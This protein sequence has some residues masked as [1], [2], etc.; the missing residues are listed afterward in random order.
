MSTFSHKSSKDGQTYTSTIV[1]TSPFATTLSGTAINAVVVPI[2]VTIKST[3]FDPTTPDPCD[4]VPAQTRFYY[5]PLANNVP[6]LTILGTN[7]GTTQFTNGFR[8]AEFW[9]AIGTAKGSAYQNAINFAFPYLGRV[10]RLRPLTPRRLDCECANQSGCTS[11]MGVLPPGWMK[12]HLEATVIPTLQSWGVIS[13]ASFV[14]FL[15]RNVVEA[16]SVDGNGN[17]VGFRLGYHAATG[18]PTQTY[19][20]VDWDTVNFFGSADA[21]VASHEI[22]EWMDDP[23]LTNATPPWGKVGQVQVSAS[24]PSGCISQWET[25]DPLTGK[26]MPVI[27]VPADPFQFSYHMQEL[28]Y[29]GFF[30]NSP[31]D[32]SGGATFSQVPRWHV[33]NQRI[34]YGTCQHLPDTGRSHPVSVR[35]RP[36]HESAFCSIAINHGVTT[37][38]RP[39]SPWAPCH[40][41]PIYFFSLNSIPYEESFPPSAIP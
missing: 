8:R 20:A 34:P 7:V 38:R 19:A 14:I 40:Q 33:L 10:H 24:N 36:T 29:F 28:A 35:H 2:T 15:F 1:G 3:T 31:T 6:N 13:P 22:A 18:N 5:S 12:N 26:L 32:A 4:S 16:E 17:P 9:S 41:Q 25:G 11:T 27:K 23:L 21:S 37:V 30:Y 39:V